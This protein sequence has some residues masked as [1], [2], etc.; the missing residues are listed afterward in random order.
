MNFFIP[1]SKPIIITIIEKKENQKI[2]IL[3]NFFLKVGKM[4]VR[5]RIHEFRA[6]F[7]KRKGS[8]LV[9]EE[10]EYCFCDDLWH[11]IKTFLLYPPNAFRSLLVQRQWL[12]ILNTEYALPTVPVFSKNPSFWE[13]RFAHHLKL[14]EMVHTKRFDGDCMQVFRHATQQAL[15]QSLIGEGKGEEE[16]RFMAMK[17]NVVK[18]QYK[19]LMKL[20]QLVMKRLCKKALMKKTRK[21][22]VIVL[23]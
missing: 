21:E 11:V 19:T 17:S 23:V 2:K 15:K 1:F 22:E 13:Y 3:L 8:L 20:K 6:F 10:N 4:E 9:L 14:V 5:V 16:T 12:F 18:K 7:K